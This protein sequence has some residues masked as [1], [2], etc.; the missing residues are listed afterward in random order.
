LDHTTVSENEA[1][2]FSTRYGDVQGEG[3]GL[4]VTSNLAISDSVIADNLVTGVQSGP[5][6]GGLWISGEGKQTIANTII[7]RNV[8]DVTVPLAEGGG[9]ETNDPASELVLNRVYVVENQ[10]APGQ[11]GG[12]ANSGTLVLTH[13][14][15]ADNSGFNCTGGTGCPP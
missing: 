9:I 11:A 3:G 10:A 1:K 15:I 8:A 14:I 4:Y 13:T 7:A 5:G 6:G 2:G 12:I